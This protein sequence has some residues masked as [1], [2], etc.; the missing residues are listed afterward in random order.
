MQTETKIE[1]DFDSVVQQARTDAPAL[2][3]L[4]DRYHRPIYRFCMHRVNCRTAAEDIASTAWLAVA[5]QIRTFDGTTETE[6][7]RWLYAIAI[8]Q[9]NTYFR[10][11]NSSKRRL[12]IVAQT[13]PD[14]ADEPAVEQD[15]SAVHSAICQLKPI[16]QT[17]VTLR[18]FEDMS[19]EEIAAIVGKRTATV[20]V[21][22][23]RSLKKLNRILENHYGED[24]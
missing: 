23:H 4:Y 6:F 15:F 5:R 2:G 24:R 9:V 18:F 8:N 20:R 7:R 1:H 16:C 19:F 13:A 21:M 12:K 22:L 17:I 11:K 3:R 10:K 14:T